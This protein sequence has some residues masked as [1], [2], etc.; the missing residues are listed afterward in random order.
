MTPEQQWVCVTQLRDALRAATLLVDQV[1]EGCFMQTL[2][3]LG[4]ALAATR[5]ECDAYLSRL[6][7]EHPLNR[8]MPRPVW[9]PPDTLHHPF[10]ES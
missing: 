10:F 8:K 9:E 2:S 5:H 3:S 4:S 7:E 6:E 1:D